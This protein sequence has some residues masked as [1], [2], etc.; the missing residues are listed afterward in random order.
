MGSLSSFFSY[1]PLLLLIAPV[2]YPYRTSCEPNKAY[3]IW[4]YYHHPHRT[5]SEAL[6]E[7]S[8]ESDFREECLPRRVS[9]EKSVYREECLATRHASSVGPRASFIPRLRRYFL[10]SIVSLLEYV[11]CYIHPADPER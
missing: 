3:E 8:R 10:T 2:Q 1:G 4:P 6:R 9:T 5:G 11:S 7:Q